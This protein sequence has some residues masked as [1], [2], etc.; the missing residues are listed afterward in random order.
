[1]TRDITWSPDNQW[2]AT[3][4]HDNAIRL[5]DAKT[6]ICHALVRMDASVDA[7][8]W[9]PDGQWLGYGCHDGN[10][11]WMKWRGIVSEDKS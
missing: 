6:G 7:I 2:L 8:A 3:G 1:K 10:L 5:Y 4:S 9:S 11:G